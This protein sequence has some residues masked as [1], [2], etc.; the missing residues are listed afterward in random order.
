[1]CCCCG[2]GVPVQLSVL[3]VVVV[4]EY[5]SNSQYCVR[6]QLPDQSVFSRGTS[7]T[8]RSVLTDKFNCHSTG[9][10]D[11][12]SVVVS[13]MQKHSRLNKTRYNVQ[14]AEIAITFDLYKV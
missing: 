5:W 9:D 3:C 10:D 14:S 8:D 7:T 11:K 12:C 1:M 6:L 4:E 2:R 13:L